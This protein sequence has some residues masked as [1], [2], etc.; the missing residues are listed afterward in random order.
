MIARL[1]F[2]VG[3]ARSGKDT[4]T[5]II[6]EYYEKQGKSVV[7]ITYSK[8]I[9]DYVKV[10]TAW[11]GSDETKPRELLQTLGTDI[12]R[13]K[14]DQN[15]F[16]NR[17]CDDIKVYSHFFDV[18]VVSDARLVDE[19]EVPRKTFDKIN[20][21]KIHRPNFENELTDKQRKHITET[22]L[23]NFTDFDYIIENSGSVDELK[24][25]VTEVL[26]EVERG[27]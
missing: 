11:D 21:V 22:G 1:Y 25:K 16:V 6:K 23:D 13:G 9:K 10:I 7:Q 17:I 27:Y 4:L 2:I 5:E 12:I 14:V 19:I 18:V 20:V 8:Y 26:E 15:Y 3:K 24:V